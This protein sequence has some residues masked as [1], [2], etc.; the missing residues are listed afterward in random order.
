MIKD[1]AKYFK[2]HMKLFIA[3]LVCAFFV[4]L[5]DQFMPMIVRRMINIYVP[6]KNYQMMIRLCIGLL[7]V[8]T[9]KVFL[10]LFITYWG[11]ITGV[12]IQADMRTELFHHLEEL[13][14]SFFDENK[15]GTIMSRII[16]DLQEISEMAHHGPEN[17]FIC[18]VM[19]V[20]S[21]ILLSNINLR[22]T[23]YVFACLPVIGLFV[24]LLRKKQ[25][26][27]FANA[28]VKIGEVNAEVETSIAGI[29][30]TKAYAGRDTEFEKFARANEA[31]KSA[32]SI[33]YKYMALFNS[34]M[35]YFMDLMYLAVV[36]LGGLFFI[37]GSINSGDFVAY[38]LYISMFLTPVKKLVET[39]EMIVEGLS[40]FK[41]YQAIMAVPAEKN[42]EGAEDI[43]RLQGDIKFDHVTFHYGK[44]GDEEV[45]QDL[46]MHIPAGHTCALV[47]PS[48]G[49]KSTIC[50]LIP[51]FYELESGEI[52]IDGKNINSM[53]RDSLRRNIGMVAQD[54]FLF[55][56][57]V[58][59]NI[60]YGRP[61]ASDEE[62]IE[63]AKKAE[64][65][66]YILTMPDG[67]D[68]NVG[69]RGLR[70]SGGQ[71]Q[72]IAI[73]RVFLKNPEILIL[74]EATSALDNATEMQI[75]KSLEKLSEGRTVL[76]VAHRL[77]TIRHA[78][79]IVV[80]TKNGIQERGTS[81]ELLKQK[82]MYYELYNYQFAE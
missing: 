18:T 71:R 24:I 73:A 75:Q 70:L 78:D 59:D 66:D 64:I 42:D 67:Y 52:T 7:V 63:A 10:N 8:Y 13:P 29:R 31:Y 1:F 2:P 56:G 47:G 12:R 16:N 55:N 74:D 34:G 45:I 36:A 17:L 9:V 15:T 81:E 40:G 25:L 3:D 68:T 51:R 79:E 57:S 50:N 72:R 58:K 21:F 37:R 33:T 23:L 30:V 20:S 26:E 35:N 22:L 60:A 54:V 61:G 49:G 46:C 5:A 38:I 80:L 62:I 6:E 27:A 77:S 43:G 48:G 82:G 19:L 69:E 4:G 53:T 32:R 44:D 14:V 39:Y 28:R 41:R 11:H 65:H 76:V